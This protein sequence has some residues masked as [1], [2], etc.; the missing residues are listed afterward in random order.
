[1]PQVW[2]V[3]KAFQST[4]SKEDKTPQVVQTQGGEMHKYIVQVENQP[5]PG[6]L[7]IL[8]KPG[9][10]VNQGDELYGD[11]VENNWGK[12]QFNRA[13]RPQEGQNSY[14]GNSAPQGQPAA[15]AG[16]VSNEAIM[17]ELKY[18]RGVLENQFRPQAGTEPTQSSQGDDQP[19]DLSTLDY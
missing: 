7:Q 8:K 10:A 12:P 18:I 13:D 4:V 9:N 5:V 17:A 11:I 3:T 2:K 15:Q 6:W 14:Q 16:N 1:M 19:V